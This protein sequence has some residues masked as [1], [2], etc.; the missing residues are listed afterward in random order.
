MCNCVGRDNGCETDERYLGI[1]G[2]ARHL[3]NESDSNNS[4]AIQCWSGNPESK[5]SLRFC[6]LAIIRVSRTV[7]HGHIS[8]FDLEM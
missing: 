2:A 5:L 3:W 1:L 7:I 8:S 6:G 4:N